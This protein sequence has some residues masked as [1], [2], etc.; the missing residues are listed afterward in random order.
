MFFLWY[1]MIFYVFNIFINFRL[2][3]V[4]NPQIHVKSNKIQ[5]KVQKP[6]MS[7]LYCY[8]MP[9]LLCRQTKTE[10]NKNLVT[11][12]I[13]YLNQTVL[14]G[15]FN[16]SRLTKTGHKLICN[17]INFN[18]QISINAK[19]TAWNCFFFLRFTWVNCPHLSQTTANYH[20][21]ITA[22]I[23]AKNMQS[24]PHQQLS[25]MLNWI[26]FFFRFCYLLNAVF[27]STR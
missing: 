3:E 25:R 16:T 23:M 24:P 2:F 22:E 26:L 1:S 9:Y 17:D 19:A 12:A 10:S 20:Q 13:T 6:N 7:L 5:D 14:Y 18:Q 15:Q 8:I 11:K 27:D 4:Q 21:L